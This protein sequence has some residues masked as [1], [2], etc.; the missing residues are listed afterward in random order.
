MSEKK[1]VQVYQNDHIKISYDPNICEHAAECVKGSPGVFDV[2]QKPWINTEAG[3]VSDI[4]STIHKCPTGALTYKLADGTVWDVKN[5]AHSPAEVV[6]VAN[7]PLRLAGKIAVKDAEG[8][9]LME[10]ER[11][12]LCRCGASKNKPFCDGSHKTIGFE[13]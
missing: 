8:N 10:T 12:S 11:V 4:R 3:E 13:G 1:K 6:V 5:K 9:T 2:K 7:G